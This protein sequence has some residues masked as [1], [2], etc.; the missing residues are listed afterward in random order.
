MDEKYFSKGQDGITPTA[1][2]EIPGIEAAIELFLGSYGNIGKTGTFQGDLKY[3]SWR[4][5]RNSLRHL[6]AFCKSRGI[7]SLDK[8]NTTELERYRR[9]REIG[10]RTWRTELQTLRTFLGYCVR[11]KWIASNCAT[12]MKGPRNLTPNDVV[13][14]TIEDEIRILAACDKIGGGRYIRT[15][16]VYERLRAKAI[17]LVLRHT[18][19]RISDVIK[20]RKDAISWDPANERWEVRVRTTKTGD[21]VRL[22]I[23]E[24][25]KRALDVL[26]LPRNAPRDCPFYFWN[27]VSTERAVIGIAERTL[28]RVFQLSGVPNAH[29]HRFR[30]TLATRLLGNGATCEQVADILGNTPNVV[31]KH[32]GKWSKERQE[33]INKLMIAHFQTVPDT[34][35]VTNQSHEKTVAVN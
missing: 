22:P 31:R 32:Y 4:K 34:T 28:S 14:Y 24:D 17:I 13:P 19:L 6:A 26:P 3:S 29:A 12:E 30:H 25:L 8:I 1:V 16:A 15:D 35:Q 2:A 9:T 21:A 10:Q 5:Y 33:G 18:A 27:G 7:Q 23:P 11:K 20:L